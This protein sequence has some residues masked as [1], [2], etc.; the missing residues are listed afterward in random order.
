MNTKSETIYIT[1]QILEKITGGKW[2][3]YDESLRFTGVAS[4]GVIGKDNISFAI[5]T[6]YWRNKKGVDVETELLKIF[7]KGA[8]AIVVDR[9]E[10][11][12][13]FN[14]P[15]LVVSDV[16]EAMKKVG[17]SVREMLNPQTVLVAGSVGKTGFKT[18]LKHIL[19]PMANT[20]AV[21]NSANVKLP[22]LY[23]LASLR[24]DD[25]VEI[26]EV[27]GAARYQVGIERSTIVQPDIV[28][29]TDTS[30]N[31]MRVHK[32]Q[33]NFFKA[34]ASAVV[35]MRPGGC[36]ILN[37]DAENYKEIALEIKNFRDDISVFTFAE[38]KADA[39][40][41]SKIFNNQMLR[42]EITAQIE[43]QRVSYFTPLF[44]SHAPLQS[45]GALLVVK[46]L[47]YDVQKAAS[48]YS[49][50]ISYETMGK[51]FEMTVSENKKIRFYDQSLRGALQGMRTAFEDLKN[52]K[53]EG[54]IVAVLG[55]SSID[56]DGEFTKTQHQEMATLVNQSPIDKLYTTGPYLDYMFD[57]LDQQTKKKLIIHTDNRDEIISLLK[58]ELEDGDLLFVMG[59]SYL[60]LE[61]IAKGILAFGSYQQRI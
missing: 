6:E 50:L 44:Q 8:S 11:C 5:A 10:Y 56:E 55:G 26:V 9:S 14:R 58:Q 19:Q 57:K 31:H 41:V 25:Q 34:K 37:A 12:R 27:S 47:G 52:L 38:N 29:F 20:H 59:S 1:P 39:T 42:W 48:N 60:K 18:Q 16:N 43:D 17:V 23:S 53:L 35:G 24:E 33:E 13:F 40:I 7:K 28:V 32:T 4:H 54:K 51:L 22:I 46:K 36:C 61:D 45:V 2:I 49:E 30:L 21:I 15:M 3:N